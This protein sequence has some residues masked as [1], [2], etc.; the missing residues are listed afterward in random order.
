MLTELGKSQVEVQ[1]CS[2]SWA[3]SRLRSSGAHSAGQV[4]GS[5]PA[6][7]TKLGRSKVEVQRCSLSSEGPRLRPSGAH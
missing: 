7:L 4:P 6:V 5:G 1:R 2:L 3:G